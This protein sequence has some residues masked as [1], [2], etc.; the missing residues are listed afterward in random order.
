MAKFKQRN[1][2]L[3]VNFTSKNLKYTDMTSE[4]GN[5]PLFGTKVKQVIVIL[6]T[7]LNN[8]VEFFI[9]HNINMG[10]FLS[11]DDVPSKFPFVD[12]YFHGDS[13]LKILKFLR[14]YQL[15]MG[16]FLCFV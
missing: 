12:L 15:S 16:K 13:A 6:Y 11:L 7:Y 9:L 4:Q 5:F 3:F 2:P 1:F 10:I 8:G 14:L